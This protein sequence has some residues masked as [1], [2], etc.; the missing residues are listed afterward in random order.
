VPNTFSFRILF[1]DALSNG[2]A[3]GIYF[4][5]PKEFVIMY[6]FATL[7]FLCFGYVIFG[8]IPHDTP[9]YKKKCSTL[10]HINNRD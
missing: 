6:I 3:K 2:D 5:G 4:E 7:L 9:V 10:T 8:T 1:I